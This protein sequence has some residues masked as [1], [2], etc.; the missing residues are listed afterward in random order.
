MMRHICVLLKMKG[1]RNNKKSDMIEKLVQN[2]KNRK[3]Y[4]LITGGINSET[5][6]ANKMEKKNRKQIQCPFRLLNIL[7]S[8]Q[9]VEEFATLGNTANRQVLDSGK[10][11]N[12]QFFWERIASAFVTEDEAYGILF[13]MDDEIIQYHGHIDPGK[14]VP[15]SWDKLRDMWKQINSDYRTALRKYTQ[16]GTHDHNF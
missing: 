5:E 6:S 9:F 11:G 14:I 8:D 10:A 4:Q 1:V 12:Q 15:H 2:Y 13:F 3:A 7:Y 16:S